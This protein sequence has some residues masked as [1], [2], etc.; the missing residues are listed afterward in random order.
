M[1][2]SCILVDYTGPSA[3][4]LRDSAVYSRKYFFLNMTPQKTPKQK[5]LFMGF[6][7]TFARLKSR[8]RQMPGKKVAYRANKRGSSL[9]TV[10]LRP[11]EPLALIPVNEKKTKSGAKSGPKMTAVRDPGVA[12]R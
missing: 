4:V 12:R 10:S 11:C 6:P 5:G 2:E 3:S 9:R 7:G 1:S 8:L